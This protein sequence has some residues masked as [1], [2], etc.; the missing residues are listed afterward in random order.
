[1]RGPGHVEPLEPGLPLSGNSSTKISPGIIRRREISRTGT[2]VWDDV[3]EVSV[4]VKPNRLIL[5]NPADARCFIQV[6]RTLAIGTFLIDFRIFAEGVRIACQR[7]Q[8]CW[9]FSQNSAEVPNNAES[10]NAVSGV[11][12]RFLLM[13]S[14]TRGYETWMFSANS[15]WV[16]P[17]GFK[18]SSSSISPGCVGGRCFGK[19]AMINDSLRFRLHGDL[20]KSN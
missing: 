3:R 11:I 19:R 7:S 6:D 5:P 13:I 18:N 16:I 8:F 15:I 9:P 1:M 14:F 20:Q 12:P 10:R 2:S 4:A 17:N